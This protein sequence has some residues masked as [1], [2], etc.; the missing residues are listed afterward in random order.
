MATEHFFDDATAFTG[1]LEGWGV[2]RGDFGGTLHVNVLSFQHGKPVAFTAEVTEVGALEFVNFAVDGGYAVVTTEKNNGLY[3]T[4]TLDSVDR[5]ELHN[6][7][8]NFGT[9][10]V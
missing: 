9:V 10:W 5:I 4:I 1:Y 3:T 8:R 6:P 7:K 2:F